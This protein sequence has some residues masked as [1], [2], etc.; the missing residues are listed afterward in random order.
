MVQLALLSWLSRKTPLSSCSHCTKTKRFWNLSSND[1]V[2]DETVLGKHVHCFF[3]ACATNCTYCWTSFSSWVTLPATA[4]TQWSFEVS[5]LWLSPF[6]S[7]R[8][9]VALSSYWLPEWFSAIALTRHRERPLS[10]SS[11]WCSF[12]A[13][14]WL[15]AF[16]RLSSE[17]VCNFFSDKFTSWMPMRHNLAVF[18]PLVHHTRKT[19]NYTLWDSL[20]VPLV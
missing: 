15:I 14:L 16:L 18:L 8:A 9:F 5:M 11:W 13:A 7:S 2:T 17:S 4:C 12:A 10:Y 6:I 1:V 20:H 3:I 19:I